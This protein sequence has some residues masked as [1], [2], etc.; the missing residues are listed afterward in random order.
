MFLNATIECFGAGV[1]TN[2]RV[3]DLSAGGIRV[4]QAT[5]L[6]VGATVLISV[7]A[8]E[9]VGAT[10]KWVKDGFAGLAFAKAIDPERA[11]TRAAIAPRSGPARPAVKASATIPGA[12]WVADLRSP[13]RR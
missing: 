10:V 2:H 11:R 4:D 12:G 13:Y 8:L 6:R 9:A 5:H 7:G 3:R 1:P